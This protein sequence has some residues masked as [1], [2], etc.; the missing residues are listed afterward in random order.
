MGQANDL[1][2]KK[3]RWFGGPYLKCWDLFQ[4]VYF[5]FIHETTACE[6]PLLLFGFLFLSTFFIQ[7]FLY[8]INCHFLCQE[9]NRF[10]LNIPV[11]NFSIKL[12]LAVNYLRDYGKS[13]G[14]I[15][16]IITYNYENKVW[17]QMVFAWIKFWLESPDILSLKLNSTGLS[18]YMSLGGNVSWHKN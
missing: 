2:I 13:E 4:T 17:P 1:V 5:H 14:N 7:C 8:L 10:K 6:K 16:K 15:T 9:H 11:Y 12:V 3:A 18:K